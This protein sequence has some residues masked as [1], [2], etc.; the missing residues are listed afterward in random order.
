MNI[1][2]VGGAVRDELLGYPALDQDWLVVGATPEQLLAL[3][4]SGCRQRFPGIFDI[5]KPNRN[6]LSPALNAN[7]ARVTQVL[8][9]ILHQDVTLEQDL[10]RRDLTINAIAKDE[11]GQLHDPYGGI[12]DIKAKI[13]RHVSPAF[14]EDPLRVLE[15]RVFMPVIFI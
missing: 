6:T 11:A 9:V 15:W 1:Y 3:G 12:A 7:K 4:L 10:Q 5:P 14:S 13:L 2:L 8:P